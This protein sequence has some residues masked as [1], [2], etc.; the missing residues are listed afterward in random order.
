MLAYERAAWTDEELNP[1]PSKDQFGLPEVEGGHARWRWVEDSRWHVEG[2]DETESNGDEE[3]GWVYY[4]T[5][6]RNGRRDKDGWGRYTRRRKWCR[7]AE[8]L[9][10]TPSTEITPSPTPKIGPANSEKQNQSAVDADAGITDSP[11]PEYSAHTPEESASLNSASSAKRKGWFRR[12]SGATK[13]VDSAT[14]GSG[15]GKSVGRMREDEEDDVHSPLHHKEEQH[16]WGFGD[17]A[18]MGLS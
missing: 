11:P 5:K 14:M 9:E 3:K 10:I 6:W 1:A 7:D 18:R 2:A 8:L 17:E 15:S 16:D 4:D 13:S 12:S